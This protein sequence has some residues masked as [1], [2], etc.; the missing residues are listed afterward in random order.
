MTTTLS[1]L[2]SLLSFHFTVALID[3]RGNSS[4]SAVRM[5]KQENGGEKSVF[6]VNLNR[7][8]LCGLHGREQPDSG[9]TPCMRMS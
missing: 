2:E 1:P 3:L 6:L 7:K 5:Q 9:L 4:Q 8:P